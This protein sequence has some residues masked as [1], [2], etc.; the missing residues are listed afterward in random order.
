MK[1]SILKHP[2][3]LRKVTIWL[4]PFITLNIY[5]FLQFCLLMPTLNNYVFGAHGYDT[6]NGSQLQ[7]LKASGGKVGQLLTYQLISSH[8]FFLLLP[9]SETESNRFPFSSFLT[10]NSDSLLLRKM[11]KNY[12]HWKMGKKLSFLVKESLC[13]PFFVLNATT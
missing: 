9:L 1:R 2:K 3:D 11:T 7:L 4:F 8:R 6:V 10:G 13:S 5:L 12:S